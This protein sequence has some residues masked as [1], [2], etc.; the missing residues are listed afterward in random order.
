M[1]WGK[2]QTAFQRDVLQPVAVDLTACPIPS[3]K[4][5]RTTRG[6]PQLHPE[7]TKQAA[8]ERAAARAAAAR[9]TAEKVEQQRLA[10]EAAIVQKRVYKTYS[11]EQKLLAME[12]YAEI[13]EG[14]R[15][16]RHLLKH[17]SSFFRAHTEEALARHIRRWSRSQEKAAHLTDAEAAAVKPGG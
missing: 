2:Q 14:S 1:T 17:H 13:K 6:R 10:G 12:C 7:T 16:A 8:R 4:K 3:P 9:A 5:K 15:S 11:D